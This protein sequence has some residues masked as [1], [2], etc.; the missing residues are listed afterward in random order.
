VVL[1][2]AAETNRAGRHL[3]R[4]RLGWAGFGNPAPG[5]WVST[6]LDRV[7]EAELVLQEA[8]VHGDAQIFVSEHAGGGDLPTLVR[9]AWDLGEV[10]REYETFLDAFARQ[11][12]SD[13]LVRLTRLVHAW[14]RLPLID[15]ALPAELLPARWIGAR[16]ARHFHRQHERWEPAAIREWARISQPPQ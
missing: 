3:L 6:H 10:Q 1:A 11:P 15:P 16:A 9:Q 13:P 8:E 7:K 14:R 5:V 2:R 12:S 4:T